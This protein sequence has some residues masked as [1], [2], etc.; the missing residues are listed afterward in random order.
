M[1]LKITNENIE[2]GTLSIQL[3]NGYYKVLKEIVN[4]WGFKDRENALRYALA[5]LNYTGN[6]LL[7]KKQKDG[8]H[9]IL[10]PTEEV[11][12]R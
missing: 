12:G 1:S 11:L 2:S 9:E 6:G 4:N 7:C 8:S 10:A 3:D 5:V